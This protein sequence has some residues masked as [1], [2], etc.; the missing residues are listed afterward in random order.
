[1]EFCG[2]PILFTVWPKD[3]AL[4]VLNLTKF[5]TLLKRITLHW[6]MCGEQ[7]SLVF[8][9]FSFSI[10]E[11]ALVPEASQD[12][13]TALL[14][15]KYGQIKMQDTTKW[16]VIPPRSKQFI[17]YTI[18]SKIIFILFVLL[19]CWVMRVNTEWS[20]C[21]KV[22]KNVYSFV[23][24]LGRPHNLPVARFNEMLETAAIFVVFLE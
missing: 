14:S 10:S 2:L 22:L 18:N 7:L 11:L 9:D 16:T 21:F 4:L 12:T 23:C 5:W 17:H 3:G 8:K 13:T 6:V 1:M 24:L 20:R 15:A 19:V